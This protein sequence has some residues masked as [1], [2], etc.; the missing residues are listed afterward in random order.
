ML[1]QPVCVTLGHVDHGKTSLLDAI[2]GTKVQAK[3]AWQIT[4]NISSWEVSAKV[5]EET[6]SAMLEKMKLK[7][8]IPG[9]LFIDTPGHEAFTNLRKRGGSIADIAILVIDVT[10]GI[11]AQTIEAIEILKDYKTPFVIALNKVDALSGWKT[12]EGSF[13]ESISKQRQDVQNELDARVYALIGRLYEFGFNAERFDRVTDFSKQLVIIPVSAKHKEG[14]PELLLFLAGL[15]QRFLE[16]D[17][18]QN[19]QGGKASVLEVREEKGVGTALD[20]VLYD[21]QIQTGDQIVFATLEGPVVSKV[22]ALL[23][24]KN[25]RGELETVDSAN[26]SSAL[27]IVCESGKDVLVGS[28]L[29]VSNKENQEEFKES[30]RKEI[31]EL[32]FEKDEVGAIVKAD[33]LGSIEAIERL[34][35]NHAIPLKKAGIGKV[36]K[37]DVLEAKALKEKDKY[38]GVIFAFNTGFEDDVKQLSDEHAVKVFDE[39]L[40]YNLIDGYQKW[41]EEDKASEKKTAF[42]KLNLPAKILL[43][44]GCCFRAS[45]PAVFGVEVLEGKLKKGCPLITS[46]GVKIGDVKVIQENKKPVDDASKGQQLAISVEGPTYG[47]QIKEKMVLYSDLHEAEIAAI[48]KKYLQSLSTGEKELLEEIKKIKGIARFG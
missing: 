26:A 33:S 38:A 14:L 8:S 32:L 43:M 34:F 40:I 27:R 3:E 44:P 13:S 2:R 24:P 36:T 11:E 29:F 1:R 41:V 6:S 39:K 19:S 28:S 30:L 23:K 21:G 48:E 31:G 17:L 4:Q 37:Q 46:E 20:V 5:I 16:K 42:S 7:L 9:I 35:K 18:K 15:A 22:K 47:R 45:H 10:K 25:Y 12:N